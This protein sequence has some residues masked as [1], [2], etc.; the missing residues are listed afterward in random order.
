MTT[1]E[2][3]VIEEDNKSDMEFLQ[4]SQVT[5]QFSENVPNQSGIDDEQYNSSDEMY[6]D[7]IFC[8]RLYTNF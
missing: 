8:R 5:D 1:I 4:D 2:N 6:F 7:E 3:S